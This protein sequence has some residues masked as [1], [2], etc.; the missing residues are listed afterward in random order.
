MSGHA[1]GVDH[2][3]AQESV[4]NINLRQPAERDNYQ[5]LCN[6]DYK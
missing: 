4:H 3:M 2:I 1:D 5:I 6:T